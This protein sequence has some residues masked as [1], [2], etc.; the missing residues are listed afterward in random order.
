MTE[1]T[2]E[3]CIH[4]DG[5]F[6]ACRELAG[7]L[8]CVGCQKPFR[9]DCNYGLNTHCQCGERGID[10]SLEDVSRGRSK[11]CPGHQP[12]PLKQVA[13]SLF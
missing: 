3:T 8:W 9:P 11:C 12:R 13:R 7:C 1:P 2:C 6:S 4:F 10:A 5:R